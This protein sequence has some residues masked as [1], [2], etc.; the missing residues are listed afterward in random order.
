MIE[1][2][3]SRARPGN[4]FLSFEPRSVPKTRSST[5]AALI[6]LEGSD[7]SDRFR[8]W[9]GLSGQRYLF[10]VFSLRS[11]TAIESCPRYG[12]AVVLA[13]ARGEGGARR[14]L[15][16]G[17]TGSLPELVFDGDVMRDALARGANEVHMHLLAKDQVARETMIRDIAG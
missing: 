12:E 3:F 9:R 4:A 2:A 1:T 16:A 10:S 6:G 5:D 8:H 14:I 17:Q 11:F 13:V 7:L 15:W